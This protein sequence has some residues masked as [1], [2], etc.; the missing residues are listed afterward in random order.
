MDRTGGKIAYDGRV[1][2]AGADACGSGGNHCNHE[3]APSASRALDR[4][5]SLTGLPSGGSGG[6]HCNHEDPFCLAR[7]DRLVS[8]PFSVSSNQGLAIDS[9]GLRP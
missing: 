4:L 5:V 9:Q 2:R 3:E 6:N 7:V 8:L 1:F